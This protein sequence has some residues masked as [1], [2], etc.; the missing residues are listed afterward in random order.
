M[1]KMQGMHHMQQRHEPPKD[2][3]PMDVKAED[4]EQHAFIMAGTKTLF[5]CHMTMFHMELH[6][7][8]LILRASLP[9]Y[10]MQHFRALREERPEQVYFLGNSPRDLLT[11][12]DLQTGARNSFMADIFQGIPKRDEYLYWPWRDETPVIPNV[13]V[14]V[15]RVVF[16]R[17]FDFSL[18]FPPKLTYVLFGYGDEAHMQSYQTKE[19]DYDHVLSLAKA[20]DWLP[21][22]KLEASSLIN[23]QI[24]R[25]GTPCETPLKKNRTYKVQYHGF[26]PTYPVEIG[27]T[28]WFSTQIVN[29][30]DPC[31]PKKKQAKAARPAR[32]ATR[33]GRTKRK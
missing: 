28:W 25:A 17:H 12:A 27:T 15:E 33:G 6:C 30:D 8:Q 19:P 14:A 3:D 11:V 2:D 10:A 9:D 31:K 29:A 13:R 1:K 23:F 32:R 5:L 16:Q 21:A 24:P 7:Y 26:E 22:K 20:P 18:E 4:P